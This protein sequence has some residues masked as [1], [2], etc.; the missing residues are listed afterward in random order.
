[1]SQRLGGILK[2]YRIDWGFWDLPYWSNGMLVLED[3]QCLDYVGS[4]RPFGRWRLL[5]LTS[6][7]DK[8][9]ARSLVEL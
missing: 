7:D 4:F 1:M 2:N 9:L 8:I 6:S 3:E 5:L